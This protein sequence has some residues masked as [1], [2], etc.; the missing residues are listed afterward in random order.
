M[1]ESSIGAAA[2][3]TGRAWCLVAA[4]PVIQYGGH[5]GYDDEPSSHYSW[6]SLV[7]R[8]EEIRPGDHIALRNKEVLLGISV[9]EEVITGAGMKDLHRCPSCGKGTISHR[10]TLTP[11]YACNATGGCGHQFVEPVVESRPVTTYRSRYDGGWV[12]LY[13]VVSAAELKAL[14]ESP[15]SQHS[16]QPLDWNAL[17]SMLRD[18]EE[19]GSLALL[20][21]RESAIQG[22]HTRRSVRV[23]VGQAAFRK[24]LLEKYGAV[25]ALTGPAPE[26]ALDAAHLY[27]YAALGEHHQSG[28]LLMRSDIHV[29]F[30]EG[31]LAIHPKSAVIDVHDDIVRYD[32]YG[33]LHGRA[34]HVPL[35]P[36]VRKWLGLHWA[37]HRRRDPSIVLPSP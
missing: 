11:P 31:L 29:L 1:N 3:V 5:G 19:S 36:G 20:E 18:R 22:G 25:C 8:H 23:R 10:P 26:A 24:R 33:T 2:A 27:S 28:G 13:G 9:I 12:D 15:R 35:S 30:D 7:P 16:M 17:V 4:G 37:Q 21:Q 14:C 34:A 6:D 32:A